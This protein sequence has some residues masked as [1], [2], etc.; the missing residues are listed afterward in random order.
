[1]NGVCPCC[2]QATPDNGALLVSLDTN[3][4]TRAGVT[5]G[6]TPQ[7]AELVHILRAG[8][9]VRHDTIAS[10]MYGAGEPPLENTIKVQISRLR[11]SLA[12]LGISI[13]N[14]R[15]VGYRLIFDDVAPVDDSLADCLAGLAA[16]RAVA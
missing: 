13:E 2:G 14:V 5:V 16:I 3:Q 6:V 12:P 7:Q 9:V 10:K 1:M 15:A 8:R 11:R 4:I